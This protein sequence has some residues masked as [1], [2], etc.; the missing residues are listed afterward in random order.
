[1][2][3]WLA[4]LP[5]K[6]LGLLPTQFHESP[7]SDPPTAPA[8]KASFTQTVLLVVAVRP[9]GWRAEARVGALVNCPD[10]ENSRMA[11]FASPVGVG[12]PASLPAG[13]RFFR[14]LAV[15]PSGPVAPGP[16]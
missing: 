16:A 14:A 8:G 15:I 13:C 1:M 11:L 10:G 3:D 4:R 9:V 7:P 12:A 6:G 2:L 5:E